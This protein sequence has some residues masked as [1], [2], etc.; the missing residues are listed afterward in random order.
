[1]FRQVL[2]YLQREP[3][4]EGIDSKTD[5]ISSFV[6]QI[7]G[8]RKKM[9]SIAV[10]DFSSAEGLHAQVIAALLV[11][12]SN[13]GTITCNCRAAAYN[14]LCPLFGHLVGML[15]LLSTFS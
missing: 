7:F 4:A 5:R 8:G 14:D 11:L 6:W 2:R 13:S 3:H 12:V 1:M 9:S 10:M 15:S